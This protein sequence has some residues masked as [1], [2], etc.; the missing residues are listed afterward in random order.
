MAVIRLYR[1]FYKIDANRAGDTYNLID[2][3]SIIAS[4]YLRNTWNLVESISIINRE[5]QGIYYA[6][7][8]P[9]YYSYVNTYDLRWTVQY[10]PTSGNKILTTTFKLSPIN[11]S[12]GDITATVDNQSIE[13]EINENE[14]IEV[15]IL[16]S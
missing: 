15:I 3:I 10:T 1:K 12:A 9:I 11:I 2:P 13:C 4:V 14:I 7:L 5:S 6:D 16:Q 8:N